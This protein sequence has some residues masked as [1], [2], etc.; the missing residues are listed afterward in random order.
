[1]GSAP[2][3]LTVSLTGQA[4]T[5]D[6]AVHYA[7]SNGTASAGPDY[8]A[9]SGTLVFPVGT[10]S[11]PLPITV[12]GDVGFEPGETITVTLSNPTGATI[13]DGWGW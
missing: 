12:L 7:T 10:T 5:L 8:T 2:A 9:T 13:G 3:T 4:H 11:L 1:M 6:V